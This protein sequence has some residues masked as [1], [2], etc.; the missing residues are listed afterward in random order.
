MDSTSGMSAGGKR[1]VAAALACAALAALANM[2]ADLERAESDLR[3]GRVEQA[4][5][6]VGEQLHLHPADARVHFV[7]AELRA[8]Q[9]ERDPARE[10]LAAAERLAPGLPFADA[11]AVQ[12]LHQAIDSTALASPFSVALP[13]PDHAGQPWKL[14][15][16]LASGTAL[17]WLLM[18][19]VQPAPP[20]V[21]G[22]RPDLADL[23]EARTQLR[24][25]HGQRK[26]S[27]AD[28]R[29]WQDTV[30]GWD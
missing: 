27:K 8:R 14:W 23:A 15:V 3:A 9:G 25:E 17:A 20:P 22:R 2:P 6:A 19:L 11:Q 13:S 16:A 10:E 21:R 28:E 24:S 7:A 26:D 18:R 30:P 4:Q 29:A 12:A 1:A 5:E